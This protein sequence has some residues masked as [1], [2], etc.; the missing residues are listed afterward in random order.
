MPKGQMLEI[1]RGNEGEVWIHRLN[2][3]YTIACIDGEWGFVDDTGEALIGSS[4]YI[5][6]SYD[7]L[8]G[9]LMKLNQ[10]LSEGGLVWRKANG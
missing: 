3:R 5:Y 6:D 1:R 4:T 8:V 10:E 7:K 2:K 9:Y